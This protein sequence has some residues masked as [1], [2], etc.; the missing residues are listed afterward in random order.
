MGFNHL[1][2]EA[3][4]RIAAMGGKAAHAN[5][6]ANTFTSAEAQKAGKK[7]G[8]KTAKDKDHMRA[9]GRKGGIARAASAKRDEEGRLLPHARPPR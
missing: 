8:M 5:G 7:G 1:S 4:R 2:L 6:T 3:R 9:A